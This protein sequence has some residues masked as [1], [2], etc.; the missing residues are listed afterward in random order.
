MTATRV[1]FGRY[2]GLRLC[3]VPDDYLEWLS[4]VAKPPLRAAVDAELARR[5][6]YLCLPAPDVV[7]AAEA[8]VQRGFRVVALDVHPDHG[9]DAELMRA[10]LQAR[11]WLLGTLADASA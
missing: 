5:D 7:D 8:I 1:P 11:D 4:T 9:G 6:A 10:A 3:D 2:K